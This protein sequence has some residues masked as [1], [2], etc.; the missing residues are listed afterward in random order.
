MTEVKKLLQEITE[1]YESVDDLSKKVM[2]VVFKQDSK[3]VD[4]FVKTFKDYNFE[5]VGNGAFVS[6]E[7]DKPKMDA[8]KEKINEYSTKN[9]KYIPDTEKDYYNKCIDAAAYNF[10]LS[11]VVNAELKADKIEQIAKMRNYERDIET[12]HNKILKKDFSKHYKAEM[13]EFLSQIV[14]AEQFKKANGVGL[15]ELV[16]DVYDIALKAADR[17]GFDFSVINEHNASMRFTIG[18][19]A[20]K[21]MKPSGYYDLETSFAFDNEFSMQSKGFSEKAIADIIRAKYKDV[22]TIEATKFEHEIAPL[23]DKLTQ[24]FIARNPIMKGFTFSKARQQTSEK[25]AFEIIVDEL[26]KGAINEVKV[27]RGV[28][29]HNTLKTASPD[30]NMYQIST[31]LKEFMQCRL[32]LKNNLV[33]ELNKDKPAAPVEKVEQKKVKKSKLK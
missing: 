1:R 19:I 25:N 11:E 7:L 12:Y 21:I 13:V 6:K 17:N 28:E 31:I 29:L 15:K 14:N 16:D 30:K 26:A 8:L 2:F 24:K 3:L 10:G 33:D 20:K 23:E 9:Y 27:I 4:D 32:N 5:A 22:D 18:Q